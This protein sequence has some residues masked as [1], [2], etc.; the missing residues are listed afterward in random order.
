MGLRRRS[1]A[2]GLP[3]QP[4]SPTPLLIFP[5]GKAASRGLETAPASPGGLGATAILSFDS[6]ESPEGL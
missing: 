2:G 5:S 3:V 1:V 6:Q 4:D